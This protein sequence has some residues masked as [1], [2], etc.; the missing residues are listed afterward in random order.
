MRRNRRSKK[1]NSK[2]LGSFVFIITP[3]FILLVTLGYS[4]YSSSL[5]IN[6]E[7][8]VRGAGD[9]RVTNVERV[10][11]SGDVDLKDLQLETDSTFSLDC[12]LKTIWSKV[13]FEV[14][15]VNLS[16]TDV[17]VTDINELVPL[18]THM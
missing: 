3:F 8:L 14:T 6:G 13:S 9:V 16:S 10:N 15:V 5:A 12:K 17:V 18:N 4:A 2:I 7:A 1:S 11:S